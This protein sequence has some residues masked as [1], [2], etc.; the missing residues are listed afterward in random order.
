VGFGFYALKVQ[1]QLQAA[2]MRNDR[3]RRGSYR[4]VANLWLSGAGQIDRVQI[5]QS[6]GNSDLDAAITD[7]LRGQGVGEAP[8]AGM[9]QPIKTT[10]AAR[11]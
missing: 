11:G 1:S 4:V 2:L 9:P 3:T 5:T 7:V 6:S 8:P 10:I